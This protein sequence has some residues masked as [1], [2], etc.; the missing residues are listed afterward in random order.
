MTL[1]TSLSEPSRVDEPGAVQEYS[2]VLSRVATE[3]RPIIVRRNGKD[4]AAVVPLELLE[5][6]REA[7][8]WQQAERTAEQIEWDQLL[9]THRPPQT[10]F[11]DDDNPFDP[12]EA[13]A[14]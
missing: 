5:P 4:L 8:A 11:E 13:P 10:W 9:K 14:P 2:N 6:M 3:H 12:E 1:Q 7:L